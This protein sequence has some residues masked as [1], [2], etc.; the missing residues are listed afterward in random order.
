M[1][2]ERTKFKRIPFRDT[3]ISKLTKDSKNVAVTGIV[4][5]KDPQIL[6]FI[7]DDGTGKIN[8]ITNNSESFKELKEGQLIRIFGKIW[9]EGEDIE[10]NSDIIQNLQ[11]L[12]F[13]LYKKVLKLQAT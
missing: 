13:E 10:V 3:Q 12:D 2:E 7:I 4:I 5:S 8:V 1:P 9:G 6:S 11:E